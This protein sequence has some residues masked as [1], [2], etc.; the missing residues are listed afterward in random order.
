MSF[1]HGGAMWF[2]AVV[3]FVI[4]ILAVVLDLRRLG[5]WQETRV[6]EEGGHD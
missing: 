2:W 3:F 6:E 1:R 4:L 5:I